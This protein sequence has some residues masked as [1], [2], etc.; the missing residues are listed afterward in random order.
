VAKRLSPKLLE[1]GFYSFFGGLLSYEAAPLIVSACKLMF[2]V[3]KVS[4]RLLHPVGAPFN[5]TT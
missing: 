2:G 1:D 5:H 3:L 4:D